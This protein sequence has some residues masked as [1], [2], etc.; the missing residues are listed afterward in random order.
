M[1]LYEINDKGKVYL[2]EGLMILRL[3]M[4][5]WDIFSTAG[6]ING[7]V[8]VDWRIVLCT[9]GGIIGRL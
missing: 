7:V 5:V 1:E 9:V 6:S 2:L 4:S 8:N 3:K